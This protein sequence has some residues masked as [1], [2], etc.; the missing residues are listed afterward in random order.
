MKA[1]I[2]L[3]DGFNGHKA[4]FYAEPI[5]R[6]GNLVKLRCA[7][8]AKE[9]MTAWKHVAVLTPDRVQLLLDEMAE[10][11]DTDSAVHPS[12]IIVDIDGQAITYA[13]NA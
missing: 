3:P 6:D 12:T 11:F 2:E 9:Y 13:A 5:E 8:P 10:W 1:I 7:E 4:K